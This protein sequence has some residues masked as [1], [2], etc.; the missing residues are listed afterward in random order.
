VENEDEKREEGGDRNKLTKCPGK[1]G[2]EDSSEN[3]SLKQIK[4]GH[5]NHPL[6]QGGD[7]GG[8]RQTKSRRTERA[9]AK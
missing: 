2:G 7:A 3:F 4:G 9:N 6:A 8:K 5:Q 1:G